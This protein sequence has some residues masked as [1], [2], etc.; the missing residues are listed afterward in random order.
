ME[1]AIKAGLYS[2]QS[3]NDNINY[4]FD[5]KYIDSLRKYLKEYD[6]ELVWEYINITEGDP[7]AVNH[8]RGAC[9][10]LLEANTENAA[11]LLLSAFAKFLISD[12]DKN[13]AISDF[14]K[15]WR[16]FKNLKNWTRKEYLKNLSKFYELIIRYDSSLKLYLDKEILEEHKKWLKEFNQK[17]LEEFQNG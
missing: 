5:S 16:L 15:G 9:D 3:F 10:R 17:I 2:E 1:S 14:R 12:Y 13:E 8:L 11:L 6:I 7:D 4:Y